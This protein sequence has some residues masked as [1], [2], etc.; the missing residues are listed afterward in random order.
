MHVLDSKLLACKVHRLTE[1]MFG[2]CHATIWLV[3][4]QCALLPQV[5][6][7]HAALLLNLHRDCCQHLLHH[8]LR[9]MTRQ[10]TCRGREG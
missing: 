5:Q 4:M 6:P 8:S 7:P 9:I 10:Q 1:R 3:A 2:S